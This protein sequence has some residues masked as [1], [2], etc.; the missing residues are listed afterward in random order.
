MTKEQ[1][2]ATIR[3]CAAARKGVPSRADLAAAQAF[4][5]RQRPTEVGY[6]AVIVKD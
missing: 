2:L 5:F 1:I 3:K 6:P 4:S